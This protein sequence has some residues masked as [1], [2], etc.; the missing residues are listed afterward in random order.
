MASI[1]PSPISCR[2]P[3]P[4][5]PLPAW[6]EY[7]SFLQRVE[8]LLEKYD[9]TIAALQA[10]IAEIVVGEFKPLTGQVYDNPEGSQN[11]QLLQLIIEVLGGRVGAGGTIIPDTYGDLGALARLDKVTEHELDAA[12]Q[13]LLTELRQHRGATGPT[14]PAGVTGPTGPAGAT[15]ETGPAGIDGVDGATG[16]TG[17]TGT[18]G[19]DGVS[20]LLS[21]RSVS[22][23]IEVTVVDAMHPATNPLVFTLNHGATG[24]DGVS[25][26][27]SITPVSN[28]YRVAIADK[29]HPSSDPLIFTI[30][31]GDTG[32]VGPTGPEGS[33]GETGEMGDT[34]PT[35]P[36]GPTGPTGPQ[37]WTG[38][39]GPQGDTGPE[40]PTG[41]T[42]PT[43]A[44]G[45]M[46][47][48]GPT[49]PTGAVGDTGPTGPTGPQGLEGP[50]GPTGPAGGPQG[51]TGDPGATGPQG[52]TGPTG[53][54][55]ALGPTGPEG[56]I[57]PTGPTGPAGEVGPTGPAGS[58]AD[59]TIDSALDTGSTNPVQN[60]VIAAFLNTLSTQ[61]Q[62][63]LAA[64]RARTY[65]MS[66]PANERAQVNG[67]VFKLAD[68]GFTGDMM[69]TSISL[70]TSDSS[71][72]SFPSNPMTLRV[73]Y[74]DGVAEHALNVDS[75]AVMVTERNTF[76]TFN[77]A[78]PVRL[79]YGM[80]DYYQVRFYDS[81]TGNRATY[82]PIRQHVRS[83]TTD[84]AVF[85]ITTSNTVNKAW[86]P[87]VTLSLGAIASSGGSM[88][89]SLNSDGSVTAT[90]VE[91]S[92]GLV[93]V[94]A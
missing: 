22:G 10:Q 42:G 1:C 77:F 64:A 44:K 60:K 23:G 62:E 39:T 51:P 8:A 68:L 35:G 63:Q 75:E 14:G 70:C 86:I 55:G 50:V 82:F 21:A 16:P 33:P 69:L 56:G 31:N 59:I 34:G 15:G 81:V 93:N 45:D 46:G 65:A 11:T 49:G 79:K 25:P 74:S 53:P 3:E 19:S 85:A 90:D 66:Y 76:Y 48:T 52:D 30:S 13:Q 84:D 61:V 37:G 4:H 58:G 91:A 32:P 36:V 17:P 88:N 78:S 83:G 20:P 38:L 29:T 7:P 87:T 92:D 89:L 26:S 71:S 24:A 73:Y 18:S 6:S 94:E 67:M 41:E 57:G 40:G 80:N 2:H 27:V 28:G 54:E 43:G 47:D 72:G 9:T 12:L 5:T